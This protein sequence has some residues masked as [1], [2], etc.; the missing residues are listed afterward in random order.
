MNVIIKITRQFWNLLGWGIVLCC[1]GVL[2]TREVVFEVL[3]SVWV[4]KLCIGIKELWN[5]SSEVT[6]EDEVSVKSG[7]DNGR[8]WED[9]RLTN[10]KICS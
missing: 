9:E 8:N 7:L 1:F 5:I 4:S 6:W 3:C 2:E 10:G